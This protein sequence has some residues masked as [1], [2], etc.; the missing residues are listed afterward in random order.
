MNR[1][2]DGSVNVSSVTAVLV[3]TLM[4]SYNVTKVL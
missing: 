1:S 4:L 2:R 3:S